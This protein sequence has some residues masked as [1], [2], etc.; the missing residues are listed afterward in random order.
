MMHRLG[1]RFIL[2]LVSSGLAACGTGTDDHAEDVGTAPAALS[3]D[4]RYILKFKD[5]SKRGNVLAAAGGKLEL[6]LPEHGVIAA[7][8]PDA[9]VQALAKNPNIEYVEVD[10]RRE[11][12]TQWPPY[13]IGMVQ[14]SDPALA[15][16]DDGRTKI[17]IID[18]GLYTG[19]PDLQG[20]PVSGYN[21]NLPWNEDGCGH[22]THVAGTI[23]AVNNTQGVVGVAPDNVSLYIVRVFGNNCSWAY[24]STLINA[25]GRCRAAGAKIV[26]MSLGGTVRS[27]FEDIAFQA[28]YNDGVLSIAAAGNGGNTST[29]YPAG[30]T[31]VMSVAAIDRNKALAGFSQRNADV[32]IAAPGVEV[33]S[34]VPWATPSV[35]VGSNVDSGGLIE[36]AAQKTVKGALVH[37]GLC[38]NVGAWEGKIVLCQRG[39][40][41]LAAKVDNVRSGGGV[42]AIIYNN[43]A[44]FFSGTLGAGV[45]STI[46]AISL[47]MEDGQALVANSMGA[48]A[49]LNTARLVPGGGYEWWNG[50]SM[51]TPHVSAVAALI[52]SQKPT[53]TNAA[54]RNAI[55]ATALDLGTAGRDS[56]F[57]Y[58]LV[59]AKAALNALMGISNVAGSGSVDEDGS[60]DICRAAGESC[61]DDAACCSGTCQNGKQVCK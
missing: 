52:W 25:L 39:V 59:Q 15:G 22:G 60:V 35:A 30:Y 1:H 14:A 57:G 11:L 13:G 10:P 5:F 46:P 45:T 49:T 44:G 20:V 51:A 26:S 56:S 29:T 61:S 16:L 47:R 50:T 12:L 58:G 2:V 24:S 40:T 34:T 6:E 27:F 38:D 3:P 7:K 41:G 18:S 42:G 23:A 43:A 54:I 31:S 4:G 9:A 17:C 32:E 33:L 19:H 37:G 28:A 53:A 36:G 21:G 48:S 8:L 55:N